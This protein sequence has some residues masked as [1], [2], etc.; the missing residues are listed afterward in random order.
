MTKIDAHNPDPSFCRQLIAYVESGFPLFA[1]MHGREHAVAIV[2]CEWQAPG[3]APAGGLRY[4]WDELAAL[5]AVD[6]NYLPYLSVPTVRGA[7][8]PYSAQDIDSFI[9]PLPE[10][11]FYPADAVDRLSATLFKL[12]GALG[13]PPQDECIIRYLIT[14]GS[15]LRHFVR[16]RFS[17]FD[18]KL[19]EVVMS[20]P[21]A[22]FV[23]VVEIARHSEWS[24]G[25]I[26]ARAVLDATA[27]LRDQMPLWLI[28][29]RTD[30]LIFDRRVVGAAASGMR[31]LK[32]NGMTAT[33]LTRMEQNLRPTQ[34]K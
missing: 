25:Q 21:F 15:A 10:K 31:G 26:A 28:H 34:P 32:L 23:W 33:A 12:G 18:P 29:S 20:L 30:A 24:A 11:V 9:V 5:I 27:G 6:D 7:G 8:V 19:I 2:G 22:Q 16:D 17:E 13:L 14:T 1:A 4:A 3:P